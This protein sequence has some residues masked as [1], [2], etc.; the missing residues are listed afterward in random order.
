MNS[1]NIARETQDFAS[2]QGSRPHLFIGSSSIFRTLTDVSFPFFRMFPGTFPK[3]QE[4]IHMIE[5]RRTDEELIA[6]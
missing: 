4:K 6:E 5:A 3:C 2:L 1:A